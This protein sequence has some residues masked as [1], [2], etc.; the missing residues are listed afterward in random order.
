VYFFQ[1]IYP[2][3]RVND[4]LSATAAAAGGTVLIRRDALDRIGGLQTIRSALID[5]VSLAKELKKYGPIYLGHSGL[6]A[7]IRPYPEFSDLW[8]MIARCAYTQLNHSAAILIGTILGLT[9]VFLIAPYEV[10]CGHGATF[11]FGL[12]AS[13]LMV[14]TYFPT[15]ARYRLSK[16]YALALPAVALFYMAATLA[17]AL[18]TW[19]GTGAKWKNRAYGGAE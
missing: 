8:A 17:S 15:L 19:R 13:A 2:F 14:L 16:A 1:M 6:A 11:L 4:P 12:A 9:L 10:L 3:A 7:S 18:N 5:D